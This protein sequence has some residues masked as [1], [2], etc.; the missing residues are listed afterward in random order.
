MSNSLF[1]CRRS[2][3]HL[4]NTPKFA[5]LETSHQLSLLPTCKPENVLYGKPRDADCLDHGEVD[6]VRHF[7]VL[8]LPL[9]VWQ[10][11]ERHADRRCDDERD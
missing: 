5:K 3:N 1:D 4:Y 7:P 10:R 11:V 8:V 2:A 6:V 9:Q